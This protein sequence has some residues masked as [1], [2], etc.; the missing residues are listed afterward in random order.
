MHPTGGYLVA[1]IDG[2]N[3]GTVRAA[4]ADGAVPMKRTI[5]NNW[6]VSGRSEQNTPIP[7]AGAAV[8]EKPTANMPQWPI[9]AGT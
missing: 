3:R 1:V 7:L 6:A 9:V 5:L 4:M 8:P 2:R